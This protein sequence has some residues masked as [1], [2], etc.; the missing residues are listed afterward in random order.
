MVDGAVV[1]GFIVVDVLGVSVV[2]GNTGVTS[3][4]SL[5]A[6]VVG[7][8]KTV[9]DDSTSASMVVGFGEAAVNDGKPQTNKTK[10]NNQ[11]S[12]VKY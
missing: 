8:G 7:V 6:R 1:V 4:P 3:W 11:E 12:V 9:D 5:V 2:V 10:K